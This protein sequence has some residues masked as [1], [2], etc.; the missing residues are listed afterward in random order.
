MAVLKRDILFCSSHWNSRRCAPLVFSGDSFMMCVSC[1]IHLMKW[2]CLQ[3]SL[4]P[5]LFVT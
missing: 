5:H 1:T 4:S 3:Q 2:Y